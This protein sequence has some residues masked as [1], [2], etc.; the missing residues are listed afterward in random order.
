[1]PDKSNQRGAILLIALL[2]IS[3]LTAVGLGVSVII[4]NNLRATSLVDNSIAGI[5]AAEAGMEWGLERVFEGRADGLSLGVEPCAATGTVICNIKLQPTVIFPANNARWNTADSSALVDTVL[6]D[7]ANGQSAQLDLFNPADEKSDYNNIAGI[8]VSAVPTAGW[9]EVSWTAWDG[10]VFISNS[11]TVLINPSDLTEPGHVIDLVT[12]QDPELDNLI[13]GNRVFRAF[14]VN[15]K[16]RFGDLNDV[17]IQAVSNV[18]D[19]DNSVVDIPNRVY[20]K[21][22]GSSGGSSLAIT[23]SVPWRLPT[24]ALFDFVVFSDESIEK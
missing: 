19:P 1:M 3:G 16:A 21:S 12:V 8:R 23:A 9:A 11:R 4:F 17:S 13:P 6:L 20:I 15:V 24:S 2:I 10:Q 5:Y 18:N 22:R 7:V 14:R